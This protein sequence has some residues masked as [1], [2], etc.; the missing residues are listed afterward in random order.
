MTDRS[1]LTRQPHESD[2]SQLF[3]LAS[4]FPAPTLP[5]AAAF[6]RIFQSK[7][8]D[9]SS[10]VIVAASGD[11]LVGYVSGAS[12]ATFY[13]GGPVAWVDEIFVRADVRRTGVGAVL[14]TAFERWADSRGCALVGL[15]TAGAVAFY[16]SLGY[17]SKA[18]YF[19]KY[20]RRAGA[21]V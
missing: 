16:E 21:G 19:K 5:D 14:M 6:Q 1:L 10:C 15:A 13:A 17:T 3:A 2:V 11:P 8:A 9:P 20:L 18:G 4:S 7:L 12:H